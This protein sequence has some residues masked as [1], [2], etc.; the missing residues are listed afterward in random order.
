MPPVSQIVQMRH[1]RRE[2]ALRSPFRRVGPG[3][4]AVLSLL[5]ALVVVILAIAYAS[6]TLELPSL[7]SLPSLL[8]PPNGLL[9]QPSR[10]YDR[11]GEHVLFSL[12]HPAAVDRQYLSL[13]STA[14]GSAAGFLV[15]ATIASADP[16]FWSHPGFSFTGI[17]PDRHPTVAQRL[18]FGLL[19]RDEPPGLR[20]ALRERLLAA[21]ITAH[22]G[23]ERVL[24]WYLNSAQYG[25]LIYGADA[26][27]RVYF[28][29]PASKLS[30]AEATLLAALAESPSL[31]PAGALQSALERQKRVIQDML[32][33]GMIDQDQALRARQEKLAFRETG[34]PPTVSAFAGLVMQQLSAAIGSGRLEQGGMRVVTTLDYDLQLQAECASA[35]QLARLQAGQAEHPAAAS[36]CEAAS[37]LPD[38]TQADNQP[39]D[40]LGV[41]VIVLDPLSGQVLALV[42]NPQ[43]GQAYLPRHA[44]GSLIT[45]VLYL[46]AFS[47]GLSP[48]S[49]VW[50]TPGNPSETELQNFDRQFHGPLRLRVAMAN[51]YL[52][53]AARLLSQ[54]GPENVLH[55]AQQLGLPTVESAE[56]TDP[57]GR[58]LEGGT[59]DLLEA[60]RVFGIFANQGL[61]VGRVIGPD[62]A[63]RNMQPVSQPSSLSAVAISR[64]EDN[65][66]RVLLD[67]SVS[68]SQPVISSQLAYLMTHVLSD[69]AARWPSLGQSNPLEIGRP[70]AAKI[71]RTR[72]G[73]HVWT[74][75][76]TPQRVVG[77]WVGYDA[78]Q[79]MAP[80]PVNIASG[81]WHAIL[82]YASRSLPAQS[83][84][85]PA[86]ITTLQVCDPSGMLPSPACPN[87]VNEI[88]LAGSEPDHI[89]SLY[90]TQQINRQSGF[91]ATVFTP[92]EL[93]EEH[94]YLDLPPEALDWAQQTGL[95]IP[96]QEYDPVPATSIVL[97]NAA[98]TSPPMFATISGKVPI[99]GNAG[100][101]GFDFY[102]VQIGEGLN[103][104][105]WIQI[106][107]D[108]RQ[109]VEDGQLVVWDTAGLNGLYALRLLAVRQD[110]Q[111]DTSVIQVTVDNLPPGV[112][113]LYPLEGQ[114][115]SATQAGLVTLRA[116]IQENLAL[117]KVE[118]FVD[119]QL[120]STLEQAPFAIPWQAG[121]GKHVLQV[122]ATDRAGNT[123]EAHLTFF[124]T[125]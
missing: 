67:W 32:V 85:A 10:L 90:R 30:L 94:V 72:Q 103:P 95:P 26:A 97:P 117:G 51:D 73:S 108:M 93:V 4:G 96:P 64:V 88:F 22:F 46:A 58:F 82:E 43:V 74:I 41:N 61:Q 54:V 79:T 6:L 99:L 24:E 68:Q 44:P 45:P 98:I 75:G 2:R 114:E 21:Q 5:A 40:G 125:Q 55:T 50:D 81:L 59:L 83:W 18:V 20:R 11:S 104:Q 15:S 101:E 92:S 123:S 57:L 112:S 62:P 89:D 80:I 16:G 12:E 56:G 113:L 25:Q 115:V 124:V 86:G 111:L 1:K 31:N 105:A 60:C 34:Q 49:L 78:N 35:S 28:G 65:T 116:G 48:A 100:G 87:V 76:Y 71:G 38:L 14:G 8:E 77:V 91:L 118:F 17:R 66:G 23:R 106:D 110:R 63:R 102:R 107:Q 39:L 84:T 19:L 27:A 69:E 13:A 122:K 29:K 3:C 7:E 70:A 47:R 33:Q 9:L 120:I 42:G 52:V 121:P 37:L 53:P 109:P 36:P 119:N